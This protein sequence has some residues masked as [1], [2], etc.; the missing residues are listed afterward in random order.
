MTTPA[1][2]RSG[3]RKNCPCGNEYRVVPSRARRSKYCSRTCKAT[4]TKGFGDRTHGRSEEPIYASWRTMVARCT[5]PN[6]LSWENYGGR[7]I[8]IC[9][10]WASSFEAFVVDMGPRPEGMSVERIDNNG[11]Y[12]PE[13]CRWATP[14]E[15]ANNRRPR[16]WARAPR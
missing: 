6:S 11:P 1:E 9:E 13:N 8:A 3:V 16:R 10:R 2:V 14:K 12:S 4:Y 5:N 15:Q 7:G